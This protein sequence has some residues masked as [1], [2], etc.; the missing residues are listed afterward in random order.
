MVIA[1]EPVRRLLTLLSAS[2]IYLN[3]DKLSNKTLAKFSGK[4]PVKSKTKRSIYIVY[5]FTEGRHFQ[6]E[7]RRKYFYHFYSAA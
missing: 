5:M 1:L 4:T 7:K 2:E 3:W 6:Q